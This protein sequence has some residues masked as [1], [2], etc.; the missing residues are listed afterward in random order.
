M[1]LW[2]RYHIPHER[3]LERRFCFFNN[4]VSTYYMEMKLNP[5]RA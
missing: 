5:F 3:L 1:I 2:I 4:S